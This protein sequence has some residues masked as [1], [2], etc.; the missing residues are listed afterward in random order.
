MF[1]LVLQFIMFH[2]IL[3]YILYNILYHL[4]FRDLHSFIVFYHFIPILFCS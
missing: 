4:Y 1:L 2:Y 3:Y